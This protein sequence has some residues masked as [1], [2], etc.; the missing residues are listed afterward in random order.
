MVWTY[1]LEDELAAV[2]EELGWL[3]REQSL[4]ERAEL[5][6]R[7]CDRGAW[8]AA[9]GRRADRIRDLERERRRLV[10]EIEMEG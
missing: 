5:D 1:T 9:I 3:H 10:R 8:R 4:S 7:V 2:T 6:G